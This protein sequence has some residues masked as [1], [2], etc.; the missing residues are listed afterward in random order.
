MLCGSE[1]EVCR[2][3]EIAFLCG[4]ASLV[5]QTKNVPNDLL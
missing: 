3:K 4:D 5:L 1:D 2:K